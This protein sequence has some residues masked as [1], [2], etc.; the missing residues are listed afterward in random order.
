MTW[1]KLSD[2]FT[3]DTWTL[4]DQAYRLH[5]DG[6]I[7][8]NRK[9]LDLRI[10]KDDI[11]RF[12]NPEAIVELVTGGWWKD[13]GDHYVILHHA[14]YQRLRE[15]VINQQT[16]NKENRSKR[17]QE[18]PPAREQRVV[19]KPSNDSSN[20]SLND[21][22]NE[23]DGTGQALY[24]EGSTKQ[25]TEMVD[26]Q[27]GEVATPVTSWPVALPGSGE[28]TSEKAFE[29]PKSVSTPSATC[30][31]CGST[32]FSQPALASGLCRKGDAA[33]VAYRERAAA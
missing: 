21:S 25:E 17:G 27:T 15:A 32:L 22:S 24:E 1:T 26:Q 16:V 18:S 12:K 6:L 10:P 2:D 23:K 13:E 5:S 19:F 20:Q 3:D 11:R 4:S 33:H 9:L 31:V 8:S 30:R 14:R 29:S 28:L 7:W